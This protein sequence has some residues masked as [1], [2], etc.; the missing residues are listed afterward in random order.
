MDNIP[1]SRPDITDKER[2]AVLDVLN[3]HQ[4]SLGSKVPEFESKM[5]DYIGSRYAIAVNSGTSA[6]HLCVKSL[7]IKDGD[8]V[9]TTPFSF[10]SSANCMLYERAKPVFVDIDPKTLNIDVAKIETQITEKTKAILPAH[11]FG[12]PCN[13]EKIFQLADKYGLRIIEDAC[14]AIGATIGGNKVGNLGDCGVFAFYPNKQM[15]TG[16]GGMIVTDSE[17]IATLCR[18]F[19]NQGRDQGME[20]LAHSRLGFN[21]RL[22]DIQCALGI[23][24][25]DRI[26]ELLSKRAWVAKMYNNLLRDIPGVNGL[27][28]FSETKRSWFVYVALLDEEYSV[29]QRKQILVGLRSRGIACNNYFPPIH[30]Q[31]FYVDQFG[32]QSGDFPVTERICERTIALPFFSEMAESEIEYVVKSLKQEMDLKQ[33]SSAS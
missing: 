30:L 14:E 10:I 31:P 13:M 18:S 24:Q 11:I 27:E 26:E 32:Y 16:E 7:D 19:R 4:L 29:E 8:E 3:T 25:L 6:L 1:L 28:D 5:A 17:E 15:T 21:Y 20:W 2:N 33:V 12:L 22:S 9:I 23:I